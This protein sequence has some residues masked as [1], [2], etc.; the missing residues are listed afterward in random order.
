[1]PLENAVQLLNPLSQDLGVMRQTLLFSG[2]ESVVYNLNR[3]MTDVRMFELGKCYYLPE[4]SKNEEV[5]NYVEETNLALFVSGNKEPQSWL[6][7]QDESTFF[8]MK[9]WVD[10][11]LTKMNIEATNL[12]EVQNSIFSYGL[13]Y[14]YKN[15]LLVQFG[16]LSSE[17]LALLDIKQDVFYAEFKWEILVKLASS[18][19]I[20]FSD[21]PK[22]PAVRRDLAMILDK[23]VK[24]E[25]L[26]RIAQKTCGNL[27]KE[28]NLFDVYEGKNIE[29]GKKSYALS[30]IL[31]SNEKTLLDEEINNTMNKLMKNFETEVG[32]VIRM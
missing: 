26:K 4:K 15:D 6:V 5:K 1:Y 2:L 3:Q 23:S 31:Q 32:A 10:S 27:L 16:K 18:K 25:Q 20:T 22:F 30:F 9:R 29:P 17:V 13:N 24:Y 8:F 21:L 19:H 14:F 11:I 12:S 7:K 28:I